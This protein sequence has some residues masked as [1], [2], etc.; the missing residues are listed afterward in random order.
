[1]LQSLTFLRTE[2]GCWVPVIDVV[3]EP[4]VFIVLP[5]HLHSE[6]QISGT[7]VFNSINFKNSASVLGPICIV[8]WMSH[9]MKMCQSSSEE[10]VLA[11]GAADSA[12]TESEAAGR[13]MTE[14]SAATEAEAAGETMAERESV[15]EGSAATEA[16]VVATEG[17]Y[18][19]LCCH[20]GRGC[21]WNR[22][23]A[24][25]WPMLPLYPFALSGCHIIKRWDKIIK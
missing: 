4:N 20:R 19:G 7:S 22:E 2:L 15:S 18:R 12:A 6:V 8:A 5:I 3:N 1:M 10:V 25:C 13:T 24:L 21:F 23:R 16:E 14:Y 9:T 17:R 11:T